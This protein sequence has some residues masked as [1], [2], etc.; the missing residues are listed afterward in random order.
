MPQFDKQKGHH[1]SRLIE[2][3]RK[4]VYEAIRRSPVWNTSLLVIV[5]DEHGG[6]YDSV[7][8]GRAVPPGDLPPRGQPAL[9]SRGF[10]FSHYG[11]RVP[12]VVVSPLIPKGKVD[13]TVYDH[14][15]ILA[16]LERLLGMGPLTKRDARANDV[17][18]LLTESTPRTDCPT[19]LASPAR[20]NRGGPVEELKAGI[21]ALGHAVQD[22][23]GEAERAVEGV[24]DAIEGLADEPLP[25]SGNI[26]GV[27]AHPAEDRTR[28]RENGRARRGCA[29]S[30]LRELQAHRHAWKGPS[31]RQ[32]NGGEN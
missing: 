13:P 30:Y 20:P 15:S 22:I 5:Y 28:M 1:L 29:G 16:T 7:K 27:L 3:I 2:S 25:D 9:N 32:G 6:F 10:D 18:H 19:T 26:I 8:P 24:R 11:V 31:L 17:L 4:A 14:A 21:A 12:A 23:A